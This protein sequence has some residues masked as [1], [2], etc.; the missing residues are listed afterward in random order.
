VGWDYQHTGN[1]VYSVENHVEQVNNALAAHPDVIITELESVGLVPVFQ[2]ALQQGV[3][4]VITDQGI[5][6]EAKK[7]GLNIIN[8]DE[9]AA[10]IINGTQAA[11]WA[12]QLTGKTSGMIVFGNGNPGATSIDKRQNGSKQGID[13]YNAANGTNY[14][15]DM[16]ADSSFDDEGQSI[17]KYEAQIDRWGDQLVGLITGGNAVPIVKAMQDRGLPPGKFAVGT[18]DVPPAHQQALN[19]G[20]VQWLID[21]QFYNMGFLTMA[22]A[23]AKIER[24]LPYPNIKT[25]LDL[26]LK[27]DLPRL[28]ASTDAW[29]ERARL[30]GDI[31]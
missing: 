21:Q 2:A 5:E 16:F 12:Q 13:Q 24:S 23:W 8:Q 11:M 19:D 25:G 31:Q 17:Q 20:W 10:G 15:F 28:K 9:F 7:L 27:A 1:P 18:T 26:V 30:Y 6:D 14:Q 29:M 22:G 3:T 4:M